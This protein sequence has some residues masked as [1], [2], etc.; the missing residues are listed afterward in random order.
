MV[1]MVM[2]VTVIVGMSMI[3]VVLTAF[4]VVVT[5]TGLVA[6]PLLVAAPLPAGEDHEEKSG[7]EHENKNDERVHSDG[8][9][10]RTVGRVVGLVERAPERGAA[11]GTERG[12]SPPAALRHGK[13][14]EIFSPVFVSPR[15]ASAGPL[16]VRPAARFPA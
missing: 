12:R 14:L 4:R 16:A 9:T 2:L 13:P 1:V 8:V 5:A 6:L 3:M 7:G 11:A 15:A 10:T